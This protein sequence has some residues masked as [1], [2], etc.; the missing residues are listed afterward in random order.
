MA[1]YC[2]AI[3]DKRPEPACVASMQQGGGEDGV[4]RFGSV[5]LLVFQG[6]EFGAHQKMLSQYQVEV[7]SSVADVPRTDMRSVVADL[8]VLRTEDPKKYG[9]ILASVRTF[10]NIEELTGWAE[11]VTVVWMASD[12]DDEKRR[13]GDMAPLAEL[14]RYEVGVRF[15]DVR[16][17]AVWTIRRMGKDHWAG[18]VADVLDNVLGN[19][20][21]GEELDAVFIGVSG[22]ERFRA[23]VVELARERLP[24]WIPVFKYEQNTKACVRVDQD[25]SPLDRRQLGHL[26]LDS[27]GMSWVNLAEALADEFADGNSS[28]EAAIRIVRAVD[29]GATPAPTDLALLATDQRAALSDQASLTDDQL[30]SAAV[31]HLR[32]A[33]G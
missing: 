16:R 5:L 23:T 8:T 19:P 33:L 26:L 6:N 31:H 30:R 13:H 27:L 20:E 3:D 24:P 9:K 11:S 22:N 12:Q 1:G 2:L 21:M 4:P 10:D 28:I 17:G 29:G 15:P 14:L 7:P 25:V 32:Q 18:E